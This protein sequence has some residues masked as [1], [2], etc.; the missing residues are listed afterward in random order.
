ME[1]FQRDLRFA[2]RVL[3]GNPTYTVIVVLVLALGIGANALIFSVIN[4]VLLMRFPYK[5]PARLVLVQ[6]V[7]PTGTRGGVAPANF[8]DWRQ[9]ARSFEHLA[10]KIDWSGYDLTGLEGP[11]QII[12]VPVTAGI[13]EV[14]G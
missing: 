3:R 14:L 11:Q 13:F 6:S 9:Q 7:N 10:A 4:V 5:D 8:L 2:C 12:G 1:I